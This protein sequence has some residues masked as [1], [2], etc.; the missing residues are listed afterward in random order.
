[1]GVTR[2]VDLGLKDLASHLKSLTFP[3]SLLEPIIPLISARYSLLSK[4][5][6]G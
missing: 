5:G 4:L 3:L 2:V 1:M 6:G